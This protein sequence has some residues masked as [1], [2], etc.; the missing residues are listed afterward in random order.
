M[1]NLCIK[2]F[3]EI[4]HDIST[5]TICTVRD[6]LYKPITK[7]KNTYPQ[8]LNYDT[9]SKDLPSR[10]IINHKNVPFECL[11][12]DDSSDKLIISLGGG[13]RK[14]KKYPTF[15]RWKYKNFV[16]GKF[17]C[18]DDPMY[19]YH[20]ESTSVMWYYGT[21][22]L[23]FLTLLAEI[24]KKI[25]SILKIDTKNVIFLG[26]SGGGYAAI[27]LANLINGTTA[28][29]LNPQYE[30][31]KWNP[32]ITNFFKDKIGID[33]SSKDDIFN[34]NI[35]NITNK[36]SLYFIVENCASDVDYKKQFLPF[37]KRHSI[38]PTYGITQY[39]NI[40]T[41]VHASFGPELHSSN[42]E[43]LGIKII[44]FL[45][46][47]YSR[48]N[49]I[50]QFKKLS[51][52]LNEALNDKYTYLSTINTYKKNDDT[53]TQSTPLMMEILSSFTLSL[54]ANL[55]KHEHIESNNVKIH[56]RGNQ[57]FFYDL[58]FLNGRL[59]IRL[60][61]ENMKDENIQKIR[62][63]YFERCVFAQKQHKSYIRYEFTAATFKEKISYFIEKTLP[64]F[65]KK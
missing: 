54:N 39:Q 49:D 2:D 26:S 14:N 53:N 57:D 29:A 16:G 27:Y 37:C 10:F 46:D 23:S 15:F 50:N 4:Y 43:R 61:T 19:F 7:W 63:N 42:P 38:T 22:E 44:E 47:E 58:L 33:I 32:K 8:I 36:S 20:K 21:K 56:I 1:N 11:Y 12:F 17:L 28:I 40:I 55:H 30:I 59:H 13:G 65:V 9:L 3:P 41:W 48:G 51:Y 18:I 64:N 24:V 25:I 34:R 5:E 35:L 62:D 60:I 31:S 45:K 52:I 6:F